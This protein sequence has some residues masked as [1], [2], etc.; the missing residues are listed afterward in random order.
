MNLDVIKKVMYDSFEEFRNHPNEHKKDKYNHCERVAVLAINLRKL[1]FPDFSERDDILTV[2]AWF[3]DIR[4]GD[5]N[6]GTAGANKTR[7]IL[8][9]YCSAQE[10]DDICYIIDN[11]PRRDPQNSELPPCLRLHQDADLLDHFGVFDAKVAIHRNVTV[12]GL[13]DFLLNERP[14][15]IEMWRSQLNFDISKKIYD[16]KIEFMKEFTN[17]FVVESKG[18]IYGY[19]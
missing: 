12:D 17:R 3:H 13:R 9:P 7:E 2:A 18:E 15:Y 10:L 14:K 19:R 16:D 1:I 5:E 8:S 11:H 6:H 4:H